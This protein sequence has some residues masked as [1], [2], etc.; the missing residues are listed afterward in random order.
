MA[1]FRLICVLDPQTSSHEST[2]KII[3]KDIVHPLLCRKI[4]VSD[5]YCLEEAWLGWC[6]GE[7]APIIAIIGQIPTTSPGDSH[8]MGGRIIKDISDNEDILFFVPNSYARSQGV[9]SN[10]SSIPS[11]LTMMMTSKLFPPK[12]PFCLMWAV[13]SGEA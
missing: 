7:M 6:S 12:F 11:Q 3:S 5:R 1:F 2:S 13:D 8:L 10:V 9:C 4:L